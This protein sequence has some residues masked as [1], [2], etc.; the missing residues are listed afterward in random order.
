MAIVAQLADEFL[1]CT[2]RRLYLVGR[3]GVIDPG[4]HN[5]DANDAI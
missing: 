4:C 1:Q 3:T 2:F 5:R